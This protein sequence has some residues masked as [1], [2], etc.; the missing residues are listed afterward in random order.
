MKFVNGQIMS[1]V[2]NVLK[3]GLKNEKIYEEKS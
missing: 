2:F 3:G 1:F